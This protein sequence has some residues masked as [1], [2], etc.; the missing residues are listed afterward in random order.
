MATIV[1]K[2]DTVK[3]RATCRKCSSIVEYLPIEVKKYSGRDI[4]GGP[5]GKEW[6][7]CPCCQEEI[8]IA[9]W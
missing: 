7:D 5:D 2:D 9:A 4:S 3:K 1:G 6:I 8:I